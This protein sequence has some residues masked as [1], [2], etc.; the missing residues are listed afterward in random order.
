LGISNTTFALTHGCKT[1]STTKAWLFI[2]R[3]KHDWLGIEQFKNRTGQHMKEKWLFPGA[4]VPVDVETT[5]ALVAEIKRLI[6]VVG[7][8]ALAQ[9]EQEPV[10]WGMQNDDGQIYDCITPKEHKREEGEYTHPLYTTPPQRK[11]K[12]T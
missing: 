2:Q 8:M 9:P 1:A 11:E 5:A 6:D 3:K 4:I 12:N 10:A 7:D